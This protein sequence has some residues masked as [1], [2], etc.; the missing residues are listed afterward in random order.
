MILTVLK[1]A[2]L[3]AYLLALAGL[4]GLLPAA[5][6]ATVQQLAL[7]LL[8]VH[9]VELVVMFKHVRLYR[10]SLAASVILTLLF[11]LLHWRPLAQAAAQ[12][13]ARSA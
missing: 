11:G 10:G 12:A 6:A 9:A 13:A 7:V 3:S 4:A 1:A 8:L 2:C 5:M